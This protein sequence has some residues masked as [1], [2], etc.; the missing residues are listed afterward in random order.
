MSERPSHNLSGLDIDLARWIDAVCRRY[1]ADWRAGVRPPFDTYLAEVPDEARPALRAELETLE[2]E[3]RQADETVT[4]G[5]PAAA[6]E[7]PTMAP[8]EPPTHP[9]P[10]EARLSMHEDATIA[11]SDPATLDHGPDSTVK[12]QDPSPSRV[13]YFG[14]YEILREIARGGMGV[15]FQARQVSLNRVVALKM[16]L[17]GQL[18]NETDVR[19]FYSEAEAAANLDHP[20]IVPIHEVGQHEGQHYFS[21]GFV[22]GQSLAQR[23][24]EGPLPPREAA[25]LVRRVS[26]AIDYAHQHGVIHRDLKPAN[27]L[28]DRRGNP[29]VTDFGLAKRLASDSQLTGSGQMMGTPSYMPPEQTSN[30][31]GEVGPAADVYSLGAT[32]YALLTGRPP[33]QAATPMDTVLQVISDEPAPPRR[34]NASVPIDLETI[35]LKCLEK[36]PARRYASA[37]AFGDDLRRYLAG[38]PIVARPVSR[39][40]RA[41]KW[42]RRRPAIASLTIAISLV[43]VMGIAAITWQ[44]RVAVNAQRESARLATGLVFD[45]AVDRF[46]QH[47]AHE[48]LLWL[49]RGLELAT[50]EPMQRLFRLNLDAWSREV[51]ALEQVMPPAKGAVDIAFS[52]DGQRVL[53][54]EDRAARLWELE[55]TRPIGPTFAHQGFISHAVFSRD[56][57]TIATAA[58][59]GTARVWDVESGTPQGETL[60]HLG[61]PMALAYAP[62]ER[63]LALSS[64]ALESVGAFGK[65][66]CHFWDLAARRRVAID[67]PGRENFGAPALSCLAFDLAGK[68]LA[69]E[70][71]QNVWFWDVTDARFVPPPVDVGWPLKFAFLPDGD[72]IAATDKKTTRVR[73]T[74]AGNNVQAGRG[75]PFRI[76]ALAVDGTRPDPWLLVGLEDR[77]ARLM[78]LS[79]P[80]EG[81][82]DGAA[83]GQPLPHPS[84]VFLT[85]FGPEGRWLL[86]SDGTGRR[87]HRAPGQ[88]LGSPLPAP[89]STAGAKTWT[90]DN[91]RLVLIESRDGSYRLWDST[92]SQ[93]IGRPLP[94][95]PRPD[96]GEFPL[97]VAFS[98]DG[99]R[100]ATCQVQWKRDP[101]PGIPDRRVLEDAAIRSWDTR[102]GE[103]LCEQVSMHQ[104]VLRLT[105]S[106]DG[107]RLLVNVFGS[108]RVLESATVEP[109]AVL[110]AIPSHVQGRAVSASFSPDGRWLITLP[111]RS[112]GDMISG[113]DADTC[114]IWD[115]STGQKVGEVRSPDGRFT[116]A[117]VSPDGQCLATGHM[118]G[119]SPSELHWAVHLWDLPSGSRRGPASGLE[120]ADRGEFSPDGSVVLTQPAFD[121][122]NVRLWEVTSGRPISDQLKLQRTQGTISHSAAVFSP[123]GRLLAVGTE[124]G[125]AQLIETHTGQPASPRLPHAAAVVALAFSPDESL[126]LAGSSDG[127]ARFWDTEAGRPVGPTLDH[128]GQPVDRVAFDRDGRVAVT[129][130]RVTDACTVVRHWSVP[131]AWRGEVK[132][133]R[134]R[135]ERMTN[136]HLGDDDVARPLTAE[137]W[138]AR[139]QRLPDP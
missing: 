58:R 84:E 42:T 41:V 88:A 6:A 107:R 126:L 104:N 54:S 43:S 40:E 101:R 2:R 111:I 138:H 65:A 26:E 134:S 19:R 59:D 20:G 139:A 14:D 9:T 28:L 34:L 125:Y 30:R 119:R 112:P 3:L 7:A 98:P 18:A 122:G 13:R 39:L 49:A 4:R 8:A 127:I 137:E 133:I 62:D 132:T 68:T 52:P 56:G 91:G 69:L 74:A 45:R 89:E 100:M 124:D 85:A 113:D 95:S 90:S 10:G 22:E 64:A 67:P 29:R 5:E 73:R 61:W 114:E 57:R 32:L 108:I 78:R 17:A 27:V 82:S 36:E 11:P 16:I 117:V 76:T 93:P 96:S 115:A 33:F 1:E 37:A 35:C 46:T 103:P 24:S 66:A 102:T 47:D 92:T 72:L 118:I 83:P 12:T 60:D 131:T 105:F 87:W 109:D 123:H 120:T 75:Q 99:S 81:G 97:V 129:W 25:E 135:V 77:T 51:H 106:P 48:G 63:H 44:W 23:L 55:E 21:M 71:S 86:T 94:I 31:R 50:G 38:E 80:G 128:S 53:R 15:V 130:S 121:S 79:H 70:G 110:G 136:L 116:T